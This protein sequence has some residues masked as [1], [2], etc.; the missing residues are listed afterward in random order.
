[1]PYTLMRVKD[2]GVVLWD[3]HVRRLELDKEGA[4]LE[5]LRAFGRE[6]APGVWA[7]ST[8]HEQGM[9]VERRGESRL[10]EGMPA[11][12]LTSPVANQV[13]R[14]AKPNG[15]SWYDQVR[16]DEMT[17][18]LTSPD[19]KEIYEACRA[20]VVGWDGERIVCVPRDRPRIWSTAEA[21]IREHLAVREAAISTDSHAIL[22]VNAVKGTCALAQ[23]HRRGF[24]AAV[25]RT[26]D[27][28]FARLTKRPD[29]P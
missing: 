23:S 7:I 1:M 19:G 10:R 25:R 22:L 28:L 4:P 20:A 3:Y 5:R 21:A 11:R 14:I 18:L 15:P 24:P 16:L 17:T 9:R 8:D 12:F 2:A 26:I 29:T 13:G 6:A 27:D